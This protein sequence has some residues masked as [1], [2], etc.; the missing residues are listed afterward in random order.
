MSHLQMTSYTKISNYLLSLAPAQVH[1]Q[2]IPSGNLFLTHVAFKHFQIYA[3][4]S[5]ILATH[6]YIFLCIEQG[7]FGFQVNDSR[8]YI[9]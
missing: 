6:L 9:Y 2:G 8:H 5:D 3:N 7:S 4:T 1:K